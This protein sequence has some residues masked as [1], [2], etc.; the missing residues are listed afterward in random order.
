MDRFGLEI[1]ACLNAQWTIIEYM[2]NDGPNYKTKETIAKRNM[3]LQVF[4]NK[5]NQE[6][7]VSY[8]KWLEIK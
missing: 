1:S 2:V 4:T 8:N 3:T 6:Y 7:G 5:L